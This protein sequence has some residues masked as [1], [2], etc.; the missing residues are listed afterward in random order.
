MMPTWD[1]VEKS[2][3]DSDLKYDEGRDFGKLRTPDGYPRKTELEEF[4]PDRLNA[5]IRRLKEM[6]VWK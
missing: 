4:D 3:A 2:D 6:G 1:D 5:A